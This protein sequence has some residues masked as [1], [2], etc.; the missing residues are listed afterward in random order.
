MWITSNRFLTIFE[1]FVPQFYLRCTHCI[2][3]ENLLNHQNSFHRGMFKLNTEFDADSLLY[4]LSHFFFQTHRNFIELLHC[5][6]SD[7]PEGDLSTPGLMVAG[8]TLP[9][10]PTPNTRLLSM[11]DTPK[12]L[13]CLPCLPSQGLAFPGSPG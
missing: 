8:T 5:G 2:I 11:C 10:M 13:D 9:W 3:P 1:V 4:S 7:V 12:W 6:V